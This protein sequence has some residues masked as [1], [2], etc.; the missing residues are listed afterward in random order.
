[1]W[2]EGLKPSRCIGFSV[3]AFGIVM[4]VPRLDMR[5]VGVDDDLG[6]VL[7]LSRRALWRLASDGGQWTATLRYQLELTLPP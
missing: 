4:T 5:V 7:D 1:V 2:R 6:R 3:L